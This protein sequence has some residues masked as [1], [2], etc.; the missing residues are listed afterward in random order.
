[1]HCKQRRLFEVL[2]VCANHCQEAKNPVII[3][4]R[5]DFG[6]LTPAIQF[7]YGFEYP[8]MPETLHCVAEIVV[9]AEEYK[10]AGL[11]EWVTETA[12]NLLTNCL[13][14]ES[15]L[16][17]F[18]RF[19]HFRPVWPRRDR[20]SNIAIGFVQKNLRKLQ[21]EIA[22]QDLLGKEPRLTSMLLNA[23]VDEME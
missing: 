10:I 6:M 9:I 13:G 19:D 16:R 12:D 3:I 21:G 7:I 5:N 15:E 14:H 23:V 8:D 18:L 2:S 4:D 11:L 17:E 20:L 1:M 22:F